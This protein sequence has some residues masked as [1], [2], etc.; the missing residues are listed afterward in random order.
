MP[1]WEWLLRPP[2]PEPS[3]A[4]LLRARS[5]RLGMDLTKD[6]DPGYVQT[7]STSRTKTGRQRKTG[8]GPEGSQNREKARRV[9]AQGNTTFH[10]QNGYHARGSGS[11]AQGKNGYVRAGRTLPRERDGRRWVSA[12]TV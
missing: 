12:I 8:Q 10:P 1:I 2:E 11:P 5:P 6:L 9:N 3:L 7:P 4:G